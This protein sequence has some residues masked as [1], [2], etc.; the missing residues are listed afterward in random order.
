MFEASRCGLQD[1]DTR[2]AGPYPNPTASIHEDRTHGIA[3]ERLRIDGIVA[4][5][6][7]AIGRPV[8]AR[9]TG[10]LDGYPK[11][12]MGILDDLENEVARQA[13]ACA[14]R[15]GVAEQLH[16]HSGP[17]HPECRTT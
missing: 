13:A 10:V 14:R 7:K 11:I 16:R 12:V 3:G 15:V 4:I 2:I 5:N 8:P 6:G 17:D 9:D 1:V